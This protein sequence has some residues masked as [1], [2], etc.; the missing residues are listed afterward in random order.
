[1]MII[2]FLIFFLNYEN[3]FDR[4]VICIFGYISYC[5]KVLSEFIE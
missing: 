2:K 3:L 4:K 1:M 5:Y